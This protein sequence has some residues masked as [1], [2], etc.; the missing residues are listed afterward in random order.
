MSRSD[1]RVNPSHLLLRDFDQRG[2]RVSLNQLYPTQP[3]TQTVVGRS[4]RRQNSDKP[5]GMNSGTPAQFP[6]VACHM[7]WP[8]TDVLV[9][10][11]W[12]GA[13][14]RKQRRFTIMRSSGIL[15]HIDLAQKFINFQLYQFG[16][17]SSCRYNH[18]DAERLW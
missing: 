1:R 14:A 3:A 10:Q 6:N 18:S 12:G 9:I 5:N 11:C 13:D 7:G 15:V 4:I 8:T 16:T 17:I 2:E